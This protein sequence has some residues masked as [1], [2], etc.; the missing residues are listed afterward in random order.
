MPTYN[1]IDT[2]TGVQWEEFMSI[3]EMEKM[4]REYPEIRQEHYALN[5]VTGVD[6]ARRIDNGFRDILKTIKK[7]NPRSNINTR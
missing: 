3:S 2:E 1:F 4:L 6:G 5:I 7:N